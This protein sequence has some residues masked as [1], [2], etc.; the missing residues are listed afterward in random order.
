MQ[1]RAI[2]EFLERFAPAEL[3]EKWDNT[4]L[5][6]GD[7]TTDVLRVMTCLTLTSDV[8]AE[9]VARQAQLVISHH[10]LLF[11]A[12]Q[13]LNSSTVEGRLILQLL[14]AGVQVYSPHTAFDSARFGINQQLAESLELEEIRPLRPAGESLPGAGGAR[15][16]TL[17]GPV[18]LGTFIHQLCRRW[19]LP[20]VQYVGQTDRV[21]T[22]VA[23][24]CGSAAE[25]LEDAQAA[26]CD[27]LVTGEARFHA[28]L[29]ARERQI[30]LILAG[31]FQTE[32]P[33]IEALAAR[34]QTTFPELT[35]WSSQVEC[36]PL[37]WH[38]PSA[39]QA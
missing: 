29:E 14:Q 7:D 22:K 6:L 21:L 23:V 5:I 31:H 8:A 9:A 13:R 34:L 19:N 12:V 15:F 39:E 20:G 35:V 28:C 24:A 17:P 10:P 11:R 32:R 37:V 33:G 30:G 18:P 26:G 3:A 27:V 16:G 1:L 36:A 25:F 4:G 2:I 38:L